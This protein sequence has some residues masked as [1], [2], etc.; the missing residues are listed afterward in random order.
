MRGSK[1]GSN[2]QEVGNEMV[3]FSGKPGLHLHNR[4]MLA[5][6]QAQQSPISPHLLKK[7]GSSRTRPGGV[8]QGPVGG[9]RSGGMARSLV[10][11]PG[12]VPALQFQG[13][14]QSSSS[15]DHS[16]TTKPLMT[17]Q[18]HF[19][20][21][22]QAQGRHCHSRS[23]GH[24]HCKHLFRC[25]LFSSLEVKGSQVDHRVESVGAY[26]QHREA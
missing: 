23:I 26:S 2:T 18:I 9:T 14:N 3:S 20:W 4:S 1:L 17:F 24:C 25:P 12:P 21:K 5:E 16:L 22:P 11:A 15:Y 10:V 13:R 8:A 19:H 6:R 7:C